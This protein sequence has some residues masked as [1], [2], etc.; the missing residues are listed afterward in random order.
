LV[1]TPCFWQSHPEEG[2]F[3][4]RL[5]SLS[6]K[7]EEKI[8]EFREQGK[9]IVFVSHD[10]NAVKSLCRRTLL[11]N[12]GKVVSIGDTKKVVNDYL[13]MI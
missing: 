11:L 1:D 10:L 6:K 7:C 2:A 5:L 13:A 12:Q 9:T 8:N 4:F 3:F